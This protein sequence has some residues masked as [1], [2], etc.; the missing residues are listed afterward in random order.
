MA[1]V[2]LT[3]NLVNSK[4]YI[5][6]HHSSDDDYLG[7]GVLLTKA[8]KKYGKENFTKII[9]W[10]GDE[11]NRFFVEQEYCEKYNVA[12]DKNYYNRTNKGTGLP[13]GFKFSDDIK[14]KY[15]EY[16]YNIWLDNKSSFAKTN[17]TKT[18]EGQLH[19]KNLNKK[20]NSDRDIIEK[21]NNTLR[22]KYKNQE[23]HMKGVSK[24]E[25]WM[26]NRRKKITC[27]FPNGEIK[28]FKDNKETINFFGMS[29]STLYRLLKGEDVKKYN[30]YSFTN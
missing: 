29:T 5:G 12:E 14:E 9:L 15:K 25:E 3:T 17:W 24:S 23:H 22:E 4:K 8:V 7:S 6:S 30:N 26:D 20:V 18:E 16:R 11:D 27:T 13:K 1:I 28:E 2:Y 10:E 21:R 19:I